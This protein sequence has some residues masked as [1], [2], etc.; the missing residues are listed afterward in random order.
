M[1][2]IAAFIDG[3]TYAASVCDHAVWA[4]GQLGAPVVLVH[5]LGRADNPSA[6][7]DLSGNLRLGARRALL[8]KLSK[9][10]A[11][12]AALAQE[13]GRAL[14]DDARARMIAA[15]DIAVTSRLRRG[16]PVEALED[17]MAGISLA[18]IGKR[19]ENASGAMEHLGSNLE[20]LVRLSA[21][22]VLVASRAWRPIERILIAFDGGASAGRALELVRASPLFRG[23]EV[24][25]LVAGDGNAAMLEEAGA[26]LRAAGFET[27][28]HR[29]AVAPEEA[30][31]EAVRS[32]EIGLLVL[33][34]SG[35]SR[36]RQL[37]VGSTTLQLMRSCPVPVMIVP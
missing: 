21:R 17:L 12:R 13:R 35:H 18:I 2:S 26:Q 27:R 31:T 5:T 14:L 23:V 7:A 1:D 3:S 22:P 33:G 30:V 11:E 19:G 16:G 37:F 10:D 25:L 9:L 28:M 29:S 4:A 36:L 24:H 34:K 15:A 8:E 32:H 20:R 6:P